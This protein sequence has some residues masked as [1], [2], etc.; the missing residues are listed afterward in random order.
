MP[1]IKLLTVP[2]LVTLANL[3]SGLFGII[4][5]FNN[6]LDFA[7][8]CIFLAAIFDF[9]D[10]FVARLFNSSSELGKQLDSLCDVVS[11]GVLPGFIM[12][13]T[14][15]EYKEIAF[16][17]PLF[18][19]LR[20][21]KFNIDDRQSEGFIGVPTPINA[22][23]VTSLYHI[24]KNNIS[25]IEVNYT[26]IFII[27]VTSILLIVE[28]PLLSLKFLNWR[29]SSNGFKYALIVISIILLIIFELKSFVAIYTVYIVLSILSNFISK[30]NVVYS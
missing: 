5:C 21:A 4:F 24:F 19:A 26:L 13:A 2:N 25:S 22:F 18:S 15:E 29:V 8:Y 28:I 12:Y 17:I 14:L 6:K 7:C 9:A 30:K 11:F 3:L 10:G 1:K 23:F 27:L 16:L 20:L